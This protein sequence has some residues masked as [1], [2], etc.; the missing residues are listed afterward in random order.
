MFPDRRDIFTSAGLAHRNTVGIYKVFDLHPHFVFNAKG[1]NSK[2]RKLSRQ[3]GKRL[4][5]PYKAS[6]E[7]LS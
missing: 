1:R 5:I 2:R 6:E 3:R 4:E 7:A